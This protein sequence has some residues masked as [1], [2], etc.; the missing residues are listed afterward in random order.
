MYLNVKSELSM[1]KTENKTENKCI[2][3]NFFK[4]S[5]KYV[6]RGLWVGL[7][8]VLESGLQRKLQRGLGGGLFSIDL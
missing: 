4:G 6:Q 7:Q 5:S 8:G 3:N 2:W 1:L